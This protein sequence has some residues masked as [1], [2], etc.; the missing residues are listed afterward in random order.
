MAEATL[1]RNRFCSKAGE[2]F[3]SCSTR[4]KH[5]R[6]SAQTSSAPAP[7]PQTSQ[8]TSRTARLALRVNHSRVIPRR[9]QP[10]SAEACSLC[11]ASSPDCCLSSDV[12]SCL[13]FPLSLGY[14][15][16][17]FP[18]LRRCFCVREVVKPPVCDF[19]IVA[20]SSV[21]SRGITTMTYSFTC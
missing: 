2:V 7:P 20:A 16:P 8:L 11:S 19:L 17:V 9:L 1:P 13:G 3:Y 4:R 21:L 12:A 18:P 10:L 14:A 15:V 5:A 6:H